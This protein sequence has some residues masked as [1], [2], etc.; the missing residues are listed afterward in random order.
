MQT[1]TARLLELLDILQTRPLTTGREISE[2]LAIDARTVRRYI[3]ALQDLGIPVEG[4]RG[5]GGRLPRAARLPAAAADALRR[6]GG[7][8]RPRADRGAAAGARQ[9]LGPGRGRARRRSTASCP[10]R[11]GAASRRSRRRSAS[12]R[13]PRSGAPG[14]RRRRPAP[15]RGGTAREAR[16]H[17]VPRVLRRADPARAEPVRAR[18][19]RRPL[20]PRRARPPPRRPAHVPDRPDE[21]DARSSTGAALAAPDGF[22]AVAHVSRSLAS[23]PW[24]HQIEVV[25]DLPLDRAARRLPPRSPS[26]SRPRTG[27]C[28]ACAPTRSTGSPGCS[29]ASAATS[30]SV[31]PDELRASVHALAERLAAHV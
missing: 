7:D 3:A 5:V 4:Q 30:R 26:C 12:P 6:R 20:V 15:R 16:P 10:T 11:S 1:P 8:R 19:P 2:R 13:S 22:D 23:V 27:R 17:V 9:R 24:G 28:S 31:A 14:R 21:P 25:L 29:R 18:R